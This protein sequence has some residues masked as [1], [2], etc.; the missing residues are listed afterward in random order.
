MN[1]EGP[2]GWPPASAPENMPPMAL[3]PPCASTAARRSCDGGRVMP[4]SEENTWWLV[5]M[6]TMSSKRVI[7]QCGAK[8]PAGV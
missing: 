2:R 1:I 3:P 4:P 7:A 8:L 5:S 6:A